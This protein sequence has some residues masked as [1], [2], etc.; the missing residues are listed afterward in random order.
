MASTSTST[1]TSTDFPASLKEL[2]D[3]KRQKYSAK[4]EFQVLIDVIKK[5]IME[6]PWPR[7]R[8][9]VLKEL[10][11]LTNATNGEIVDFCYTPVEIVENVENVE[12]GASVVKYSFT[13][14]HADLMDEFT[15]TFLDK[16]ENDEDADNKKS[17]S[18]LHTEF[19]NLIECRVSSRMIG[20]S[21]RPLFNAI[22]F[23]VNSLLLYKIEG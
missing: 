8:D 22:H 12:N 9:S 7:E 1:S 19:F 23:G 3:F 21:I 2:K 11:K 17:I 4:P 14:T 15:N 16:Y 6:K 20:E 10:G 5:M 13:I 18:D